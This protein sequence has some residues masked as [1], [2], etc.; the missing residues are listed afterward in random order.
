MTKFEWQKK[1]SDHVIEHQ[2]ETDSMGKLKCNNP[3]CSKCY[4]RPK[5]VKPKKRLLCK[6]GIHELHRWYESEY[7]ICRHCGEQHD[8]D[9]EF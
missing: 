4:P 8:W 2:F 6:L 9:G 7:G 5:K 3:I 1:N